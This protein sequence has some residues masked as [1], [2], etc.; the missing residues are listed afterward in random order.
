MKKVLA[1]IL[2]L[3]MVIAVF[4]ACGGEKN[5]SN[6]DE[7]V[8]EDPYEGI[9]PL[10]APVEIRYAAILGGSTESIPIIAQHLGAWEKA[11]ITFSC[12]TYGNGPVIVEAM[13]SDSWDVSQ[14]G[15][16]GMCA[17]VAQNVG[18][19][20]APLSTDTGLATAIFASKESAIA[21]AGKGQL[22][23]YPNLYADKAAWTGATV[24]LPTG[25]TIHYL[26]GHM[27]KVIGVSLDSLS[28]VHMDA[29]QVNSA[30][31]AGQAEIGG[32][33]RPLSFNSSLLDKFVVAG[34][35]DSAK[36]P[37]DA[38]HVCTTKAWAEKKEAVLL[39]Y[40]IF[41]RTVDWLHASDENFNQAAEWYRQWNEENGQLSTLEDCKFALTVAPIF[42]VDDWYEK[43]HTSANRTEGGGYMT[44]Y[45][46]SQYDQLM[47]FI[48][49]GKY[50]P[51]V[52]QKFFESKQFINDVVD[53]IYKRLRK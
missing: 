21:K 53:E 15:I 33:W 30:M 9:T 42:D 25:T 38:N 49:Q 32:L 36:L 46:A 23:D 50:E 2:A 17:S 48:S 1:L 7:L 19:F 28:L 4:A 18:L 14:Y 39:Y 11:N 29:A 51:Q 31:L 34:D 12:Q 24:Y 3:A 13:K 20:M 8:G 43:A 22:A 47:F 41:A 27:M 44:Q 6:T 5:P 16:G 40:E 52:E 37:M 45:Q 26:L 35:L 10:K